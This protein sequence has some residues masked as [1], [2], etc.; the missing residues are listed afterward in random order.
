MWT[1]ATLSLFFFSAC[2]PEHKDEVDRLNKQSY[3]FHY[4][5]LDS[6]EN[7][8]LKALRLSADYSDGCAEA[9]NNLAFVNIARMNYERAYLYIDSVTLATDNQLEL[10]IADVQGMR[11]CQRMSRNKEFYDYSERAKA[12]IK[13]VEEEKHTLPPRLAQRYIYA[14]SEYGIV[15]STY[16][17]YVG[18]TEQ[19]VSALD[20]IPKTEL[21]SDTAQYLNFLYQVGSG[22]IVSGASPYEICLEEFER[23]FECYLLSVRHGYKYWE[24]N[25]MQSMSEHLSDQEQRF[26]ISANYSIAL[27]YLNRDA[28]PDSLLAGYLAQ[29]SLEL[30]LSYGDVYQISGSYRTLA[31]CYWT[32]GDYT[33]ALICLKNALSDKRIMQA[34]D[35]VSSIREQLSLTYSALDDKPNSDRNRNLYLDVQE[36]TR[37]DRELEARAEQLERTSIRLNILAGI[38]LFLLLLVSALIVI[39]RYMRHH[40]NTSTYLDELMQPLHK[41]EKLNEQHF[42]VLAEQHE[43]IAEELSVSYQHIDNNK[44]RNIDNRA[45]IFLA[46]SI[47]PYIDRI[48]N[49]I[50]HLET[51]SETKKRRGDRLEYITELTENINDCNTVLTHWIQLHQGQLNMHI[52]SFRLQDVFD[53]VAHA[54]MSFRLKGLTFT[55]EP[56]TAVI[57]ADRVLTLFMLN[58]LADNSRKFTKAGG[59]VK[60]RAVE[61]KD[62][63]E[64]SV[65]D[66]GQGLSEA[67]LTS[68]FNR[69]VSDGHGFGLQNCRGIIEKYRKVS[70]IFNVCGLFAESVLGKGS[71]FFFRLPHGVIRVIFLLALDGLYVSAQELPNNDINKDATVTRENI[72]NLA[73]AYA[74]SAYYSNVK[75]NYAQTLRYAE[76]AINYLN[77][78][79]QANNPSKHRLMNFRDD[80]NDAQAEIEWFN[81]G[82][83]IDY[84]VILDLRNEVAVAA[85]ALHDWELYRYNNKIYT[86]LFKLRSADTGL[87]EYCRTMQRSSSNQTIAIVVLV[88]LLVAAIVSYYLLYYRHVLH[89]RFCVDNVNAINGILLSSADSADKLRQIN[90]A[91]VSKYPEALRGVINTIKEA[92]QR[93]VDQSGRDLLDIEL[94]GDE[95]RRANY[96]DAKLHICNNI[97]DNCLSTLKHE[98]MYYPS[99]IRQL[100]TASNLD[101]HAISEV[102]AYYKELYSILNRQAMDIVD[103]VKFDSHAV[104]VPLSDGSATHVI[105]DET[106]VRYLLD[107]I[108]A[109]NGGTAPTLTKDSENGRYVILR[110]VCPAISISDEACRVIFTPAIGN[111]PYLICR[112][113]VRETGEATNLHACGITAENDAGRLALLLTLPHACGQIANN[114]NQQNNN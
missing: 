23:L 29:K 27:E 76:T 45:K 81:A 3:A 34:P 28:M 39:L 32:L 99:R 37:Q 6:T 103:S 26:W 73:G 101:A 43:R 96:E 33:S 15:R 70:Q 58:T 8:A 24:A 44:R 10:L 40:K 93:S 59:E 67:D 62:Y 9:Y 56:T 36:Q 71:R 16:Y 41:W 85:L 13:R 108:R 53:I 106:L 60:I 98:T 2:T 113:I 111:I 55:V 72:E 20:S 79:Y 89:F 35:L 110:A 97:T 87:A 7:Y 17:Y 50:H 64:V 83:N 66:T 21:K 5:D 77:A 112:Q 42:K 52:E 104:C 22:G 19:S 31:S 78:D 54:S 12:R 95:L 107:L 63:V 14:K 90:E 57:K 82:I 100:I 86:Q 80:G 91:D 94:A 88:F 84:N 1:I 74:D 92:L 109:Q 51:S 18:L 11:L 105:G 30:F 65:S 102:A 114:I 68:I 48:L 75:G 25:S 46:N 69:K 49:E 4:R 38:I 61:N 47:T